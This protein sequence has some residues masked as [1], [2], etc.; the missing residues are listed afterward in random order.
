MTGI[1]GYLTCVSARNDLSAKLFMGLP[2]SVQIATDRG[3]VH[4]INAIVKGMQR[5]QSDGELA[6]YQLTVCGALSL[7]DKRINSAAG[8][9]RRSVTLGTNGDIKL[10]SASHQWGDPSTDQAAKTNF[11]AQPTNQRFKLHYPGEQDAGEAGDLPAAANKTFRV[12][13]DDGRVIEGKSDASGLT[14]LIKN[15]AMRI[16]KIEYLKPKL[17]VGR[18]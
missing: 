4:T 17:R 5:G 15:D 3:S 2:V 6:V 16:A 14:D 10:L 9:S 11:N 8:E 12:T 13:L 18:A 1:Q 7:M